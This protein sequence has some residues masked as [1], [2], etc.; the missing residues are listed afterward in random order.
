MG[1][2]Q[3]IRS[4]LAGGATV[5]MPGVFDALTARLATQAGFEVI[6]I[7]GYSV[8]ATRL[9]LPDYG[10]LTQTEVV[11]AARSVC[12]NTDLPVICDADTGYGTL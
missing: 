12:A 11:E 6:F 10:Y 3:T 8:S 5:N 4:L 1:K 9:G 7:S 2:T